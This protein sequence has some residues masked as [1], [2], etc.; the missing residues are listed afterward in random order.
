MFTPHSFYK[1]KEKP[2]CLSH[3]ID[4]KPHMAALFLLSVSKQT[5]LSLNTV[6]VCMPVPKARCGCGRFGA[7]FPHCLEITVN[8]PAALGEDTIGILQLFLC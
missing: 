3:S 6:D 8:E 2:I 1:P 4:P 7:H 5:V